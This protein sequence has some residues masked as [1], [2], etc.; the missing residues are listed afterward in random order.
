MY[1]YNERARLRITMGPVQAE[2]L[3][4]GWVLPDVFRNLQMLALTRCVFVCWYNRAEVNTVHK[5]RVSEWRGQNDFDVSNIAIWK[6]AVNHHILC[7]A[8]NHLDGC[9]DQPSPLEEYHV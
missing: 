9:S 6:A 2:F 8:T 3:R 1:A 7:I 5:R 4:Y